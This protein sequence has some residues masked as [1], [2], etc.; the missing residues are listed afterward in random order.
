MSVQVRFCILYLVWAEVST[1]MV[2]GGLWVVSKACLCL[3]ILSKAVMVKCH[4]FASANDTM[5]GWDVFAATCGYYA[6][7]GIRSDSMA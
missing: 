1:E 6:T 4:R 7:W 3:L 2:T 5:C